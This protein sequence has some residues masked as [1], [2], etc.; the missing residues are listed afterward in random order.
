MERRSLMVLIAA[1]A[2]IWNCLGDSSGARWVIEEPWP[3]LQKKADV[4]VVV[5]VTSTQ[6]LAKDDASEIQAQESRL[7]VLTVLK[8][9]GVPPQLRLLHYRYKDAGEAGAP[10]LIHS[11]CH[12]LKL[13]TT[14]EEADPPASASGDS[15]AAKVLRRGREGQYLMFLTRQA[16]GRIVPVTGHC[17]PA[18]SIFALTTAETGR[19]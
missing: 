4:V 6:D 2:V 5:T 9:E 19:L 11:P 7:R 1:I 8:G 13:K 17:D 16:D 10:V 18:N 14:P 15:R 3:E 12:Y